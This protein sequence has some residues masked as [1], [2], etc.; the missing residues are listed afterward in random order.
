[1]EDI[2]KKLAE[3]LDSPEELESLMGMA[4]TLL[5]TPPDGETPGESNA[6]STDSG[7]LNL[8]SNEMAALMKMLSAFK[9]GGASDDRVRLLMALK[10]H[11]SG[12][13]RKKADQ[14]AKML[15]LV[16]LLPLLKESGIF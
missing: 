8:S 11:L 10:P 1:M 7:G 9:G 16:P 13:R 2:A 5:G 14:A 15:R 3:L 4:Q 12:E 6:G